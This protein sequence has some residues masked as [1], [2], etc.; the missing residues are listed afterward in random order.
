MKKYCAIA[1]I[2][3]LVA[4]AGCDSG[5]KS[6]RGFTLP[7]GD[8][9]LG[10]S[11]FVKLK[12]NSCHQIPGVEQLKSGDEE[13]EISVKLGGEVTRIKT[14]GELVTSI[15]NPSHRL[16]KGYPAQEIQQGGVS[17]MRNYNDVMT[18]TELINLVAFLQSEYK[19][20]FY[21]PTRYRNYKF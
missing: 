1:V 4:L 12:C 16:V 14:Y 18:V 17:K 6:P 20:K 15:I 2:G 3:L 19:L 10:K 8:A 7:E 9:A 5:P 11:V 13:P 21:D